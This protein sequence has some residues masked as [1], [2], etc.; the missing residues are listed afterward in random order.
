MS[1]A[2][3]AMQ[4]PQGRS[5]AKHYNSSPCRSTYAASAHTNAGA[6]HQSYRV[7]LMAHALTQRL[8]LNQICSSDTLSLVLQYSC[9]RFQASRGCPAPACMGVITKVTRVQAAHE[10]GRGQ[11]THCV[12][13]GI[14]S[15]R[16]CMA[17]AQRKLD[18]S[19]MLHVHAFTTQQHALATGGLVVM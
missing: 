10:R 12:R 9:R 4:H 3:A 8:Y 13:R 6:G 5:S 15:S 14:P 7:H 18:E 17:H 19:W 16:Y 11:H 1:E 2:V